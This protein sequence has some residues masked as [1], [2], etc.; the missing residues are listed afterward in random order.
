MRI[1]PKLLIVLAIVASCWGSV[2][3][4]PVRPKDLP[5]VVFHV[6]ALKFKEEVAKEQIDNVCRDFAKLQRKIPE[7]LTY[8]AG[9]NI[10]PEKLNKG[11]THCFILSFK[12][13]KARDA[14]LVHPAHKEFA[15]SLG[16][17]LAD[18]FVIDFETM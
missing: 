4:V 1:S 15:K 11:F 17:V 9:V 14:Y 3:M 16:P 10:S 6:V 5:K 7:I 18:V 13:T 8:K 12:D 2:A